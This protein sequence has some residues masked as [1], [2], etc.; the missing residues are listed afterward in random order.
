MRH[1]YDPALPPVTV[2]LPGGQ[3]LLGG[4]RGWRR[5]AGGGWLAEMT[6]PWWQELHDGGVEAVERQLTLPSVYVRPVD[7]VSYGK[8]HNRG[9][10]ELLPPPAPPVSAEP[11]WPPSGDRW[12][13]APEHYPAG[14]KARFTVHHADCFIPGGRDIV[15]G[16]GARAVLAGQGV[17]ACSLCG[18]DRLREGL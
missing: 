11:T 18:A 5:A 3:E 12:R 7:G 6:L 9:K 13:V 8:V 2:I 17:S 4:M 1:E 15:S 10:G 14:A 16:K